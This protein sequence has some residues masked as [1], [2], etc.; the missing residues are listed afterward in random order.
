MAENILRSMAKLKFD[1][2]QKCLLLIEK[3]I[4]HVNFGFSLQEYFTR[5]SNYY[6]EVVTIVH[7]HVRDIKPQFQCGYINI[8]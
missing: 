8:T 5:I 6:I 3:N 7:V 2:L 4:M 1:E